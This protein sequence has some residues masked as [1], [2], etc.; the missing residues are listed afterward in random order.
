MLLFSILNSK[1]LAT[2]ED[3]LALRRA[4]IPALARKP[5]KPVTLNFHAMTYIDAS[6]LA[7]VCGSLYWFFPA[8]YLLAY[9]HFEGYHWDDTSFPDMLYEWKETFEDVNELVDTTVF[10]D[11]GLVRLHPFLRGHAHFRGPRGFLVYENGVL[12]LV[13]KFEKGRSA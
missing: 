13:T 11:G 8:P 10:D 4:L 1:T 6:L 3:A 7:D 2:P 5:V 9:L 12:S